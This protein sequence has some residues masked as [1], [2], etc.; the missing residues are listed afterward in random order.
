MFFGRQCICHLL[1]LS[2][3]RLSSIHVLSVYVN[4]LFAF[5]P[6]VQYLNQLTDDDSTD[7]DVVYS[8]NGGYML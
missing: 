2:T 6:I 5:Y 7:D 3:F 1:C 4:P 8:E